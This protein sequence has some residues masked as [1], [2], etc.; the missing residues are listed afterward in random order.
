M[1]NQEIEFKL[2]KLVASE[3]E[4]LVEILNLINLAAQRKFFLNQGY[5]S[6]FDWLTKRFGYSESAAQRRIQAARLMKA[7]PEVSNK[8][9]TGSVNLTTLAKTQSIIYQQEKVSGEPLSFDQKIQA[10]ACIEH[11]PA[12]LAE[13]SLLELFPETR[14]VV[15]Q[16]RCVSLDAQHS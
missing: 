2:E 4:L 15:Q 11:K 5:S 10:L 6:L 14:N 16:E 1:T 9:A 8:I 12:L 3:R 7:L 13:K